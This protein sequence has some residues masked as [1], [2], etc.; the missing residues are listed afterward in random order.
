M[1]GPRRSVYQFYKLVW[2]GIDLVYPPF[3]AGCGAKGARWCSHCQQSVRL[4][5][6]PV[7]D[8]CGREQD[9]PG[10]CPWCQ[11]SKPHFASI[12]S[13]GYFEGPL[14][15]AIHALKYRR[16]LGLGEVLSG[17]LIQ[18]LAESIWPLDLIVPVPLGVARLK[19]RGYNQSG[20]IARPLASETGLRYSP[21]A[22]AR[23]RETRTQ[24]GLSLD[25]RK[26]NVRGAFQARSNL[27][28]GK[29]VLLVDDVMTTGSTLEACAVALLQAGAM[30]VY[31]LTLARV[32]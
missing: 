26:E 7:C 21:R 11:H 28:A 15:E 4:V 25:R 5:M 30:K 12:R 17:S 1:S 29:N 16:D 32:S 22:L 13:W 31:G 9:T 27:V 3:C 14:R 10:L 20:L 18:M 8:C 6:P 19:E 23:V 24:V 2:Q